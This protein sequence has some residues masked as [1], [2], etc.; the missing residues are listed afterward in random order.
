MSPCPNEIIQLRELDDQSIPI[1]LVEW[2]LVQIRMDER[3][4]RWSASLFLDALD[5]TS[6]TDALVC[7]YIMFLGGCKR[8]YRHD[9]MKNGPSE[10][11]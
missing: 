8:E 11:S 1:I 9:S 5:K 3:L 2:T 7:T 10:F 4:L 6:A